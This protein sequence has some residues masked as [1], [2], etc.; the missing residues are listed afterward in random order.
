[1]A[2]L[3]TPRTLTLF[4]IGLVLC[5]AL[6]PMSSWSFR[7]DL[8]LAKSGLTGG[9][10]FSVLAE[11]PWNSSASMPMMD[12]DEIHPSGQKEQFVQALG[13]AEWGY[14]P[15]PNA[16]E[17][18]AI[19][20]KRLEPLD[21]YCTKN[22]KDVM[23]LA[24]LLRLAF[25]PAISLPYRDTDPEPKPKKVLPE[26][27][28]VT[29]YALE[30]AKRGE[31]LEPDNAYWTISRGALSE[32]LSDH[33]DSLSCLDRAS[34]MKRYEEYVLE[35]ASA[36][37][38]TIERRWGYRGEGV[39][40][41]LA[42][43]MLFPQV[44][45]HRNWM[46]ITCKPSSDPKA[47]ASRRLQVY[48]VGY[49]I[50][51]EAQTLIG[52]LIGRAGM[53]AAAKAGAYAKEPDRV[54]RE[55][56]KSGRLYRTFQMELAKAGIDTEGQNVIEMATQANRLRDAGQRVIAGGAGSMID[57]SFLIGSIVSALGLISLLATLAAC[58]VMLVWSWRAPSGFD[59]S[60]VA[61]GLALIVTS[62]LWTKIHV[63]PDGSSLMG[64]ES[65]L[66]FLM[67]AVL[68]GL[69]AGTE[70]FGTSE[71][72]QKGANMVCLLAGLSA[73]AAASFPFSL[74][75]AG[76]NTLAL[77][78]FW[79]AGSKLGPILAMIVMACLAVGL[80]ASLPRGVHPG[81]HF[82]FSFCM[83]GA[84]FCAF[85]SEKRKLAASVAFSVA[86]VGYFGAAAF[87]LSVNARLNPFYN[88]FLTEAH[89]ARVAANLPRLSTGKP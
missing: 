9:P 5:V 40:V 41:L 88:D 79:R 69:R 45:N 8:D 81:H 56:E 57:D 64:M 83:A 29:K 55:A 20:T 32:A 19:L 78:F 13:Y 66:W 3:I 44:A 82:I 54:V 72:F 43:G 18:G 46:R 67:M 21:A 14:N 76:A 49:L 50:T 59:R 30:L 11:S 26:R 60:R 38:E 73:L 86:C 17:W 39:R 1:M 61:L 23:A 77:V 6:A 7:N 12:P 48:K 2:R 4:G 89:R 52:Q 47:D 25:Q 65:A 35:A 63:R 22:P 16:P 68:Y 36:T 31:A 27:E 53:V 15:G 37:R 75:L 42:A 51:R 58:G 24:Q 10:A 33:S 34:Q 80:V 84:L 85:S 74:L 62:V 87:G 71:G 28:R 70:M